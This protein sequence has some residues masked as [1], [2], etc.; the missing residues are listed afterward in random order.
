MT[1]LRWLL[2]LL[3]ASVAPAELHPEFWV[4]PCATYGIRWSQSGEASW[5]GPGFHGRKMANGKRFDQEKMTAAHPSLPMGTP[6]TVC[7]EDRPRV[8]VGGVVQDRGPYADGRI[9]DLSRGMA[10][11]LGMIR[12]GAILVN[13]T[14]RGVVD[15]KIVAGRAA[16]S[17]H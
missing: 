16:V 13:I 4:R 1:R 10:R 12:R 14:L 11:K 15:L 17:F 9:L 5:Y 7:R 2:L 3:P 8:C 6:I